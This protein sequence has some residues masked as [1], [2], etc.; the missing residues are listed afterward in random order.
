MNIKRIAPAIGVFFLAPL[1]AEY[2]IGYD[3]STGDF[4]ALL[5]GLLFFGPLYGGPALIIR[6]V[7]RRSGRGWLTMILLAFA[8]GVLHPALIDHSLF[9]PSYRDI[10]YWQDELGPTYIAALGIGAEPALNFIVG[11]VIWSFCAPIALVETFVPHRRT[12]PWLGALGLT[13][14]VVLYLLVSALI[15]LDHVEQEQFLPSAPQLIGAAA[16]VVAFVVAAFVVG[17]RPRPTLDRPAPKPWLVGALAFVV[18]NLLPIVEVVLALLEVETSFVIDWRG[19][20]LNIV[21]LAALAIMTSRWSAREGWGA[22]HRLALAGG[23]LLTRVWFAFLVEPLGEV[24]L[25]DKLIH[26]TVFALGALALLGAA[27]RTVIATGSSDDSARDGATP[28]FAERP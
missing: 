26:N 13:T 23:A 3:T 22:A 24:A 15:F 12:T 1:T 25:Y 17:G 6:E 11:H 10:E 14:I 9:N 16:V 5:F 8:F 20:V 2:L 21:L 28:R 7:A 4:A 27:A 18:L 19:V